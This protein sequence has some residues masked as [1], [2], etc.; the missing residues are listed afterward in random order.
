MLYALYRNDV[1]VSPLYRD[2]TIIPECSVIYQIGFSGER[3]FTDP[4]QRLKNPKAKLSY[5]QSNFTN[6]IYYLPFAAGLPV[7]LIV[8]SAPVSGWNLTVNTS[9]RNRLSLNLEALL[10]DISD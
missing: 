5:F 2:S 4:H 1:T 9:Y 10:L 8:A 6:K 7:A 3:A